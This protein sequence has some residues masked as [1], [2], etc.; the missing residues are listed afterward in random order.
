M[1]P[2][3]DKKQDVPVRQVRARFDERTVRV[4]QAYSHEIA[5]AA[6]AAQTFKPPFK[7]ERMTWIKPSLTWMMYRAGWGGKVGQERVLGI[8][9]LRAGFEWALAHSALSHF[10]Q[11]M[12]SSVEEWQRLIE[13]SPVRL[14]W[15]PERSITLEALPW[16]A[17]QVGLGGVAVDAYVDTWIVGVEDMTPLVTELKSLVAM[18][19]IVGAERRRPIERPYPLPKEIAERAGCQA[20][21]VDEDRRL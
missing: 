6:L 1:S 7:R 4:Y 12:H 5:D 10:D 17:I 18:G 15:D 2:L 13:Q 8:D 3:H 14:Q 9:I 20:G 16:R 11:T 19:D 21:E